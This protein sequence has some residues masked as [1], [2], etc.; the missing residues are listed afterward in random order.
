MPGHFT[1]FTQNIHQNLA[2]FIDTE[3]NHIVKVTRY[4]IGDLIEFTDGKGQL[5]KGRLTEINKRNCIAEIHETIIHELP[6]VVIA[7]G[8]LKNSDRMEWAVEKCTELGVKEMVFLRTKNS[9]RSKINLD[10]LTKTAISAVKQSHS[11]WLPKLRDMEFE[12]FIN[13]TNSHSVNSSEI[14]KCIAYCDIMSLVNE[15]D[16]T[17]VAN[18]QKDLT[19]KINIDSDFNS[20]IG[21]GREVDFRNVHILKLDNLRSQDIIV[22]GPEGDFTESEIRYAV[23]NGFDLL[24][25]GNRILRSETAVISAVACANSL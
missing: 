8:I 1:F 24:D 13:D 12:E 3:Y 9:E 25:M 15:T 16:S 11:T 14:K 19:N 18:Y 23:I 22:V 21:S 5:F 2:E 10:R 17:S 6:N 20:K 4:N 7:M